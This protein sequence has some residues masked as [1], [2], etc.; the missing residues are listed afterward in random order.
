MQGRE[1]REEREERGEG[2]KGGK[3][4]KKKGGEGEGRGGE[5]RGQ[6]T[7]GEEGR[8]GE[9][10]TEV[11]NSEGFQT[12]FSLLRQPSAFQK[13]FRRILAAVLAQFCRGG[14]KGR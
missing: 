9:G 8:G 4:G 10:K 2:R 3:G 1:G 12:D 14:R 5:G 7:T 11:C 13:D 6:E